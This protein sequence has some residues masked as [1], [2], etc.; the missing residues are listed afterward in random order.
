MRKPPLGELESEVLGYLADHHPIST[1]LMATEFGEP[2]N[3]ART[4]ILTVME[5]LRAKGYLTRKKEAGLFLYSPVAPKTELLRDLVQN[6]VEK[7][8]GGSI[9]PFVAYL[10]QSRKLSDEE[11]DRLQRLVDELRAERNPKEQ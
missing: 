2:R 8:I 4:T 11:L 5:N 9:S 1:R 10:D 7:T 3:L 6:F